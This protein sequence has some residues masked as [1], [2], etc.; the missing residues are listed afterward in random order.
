MGRRQRGFNLLE[1]M[2]SVVVLTAMVVTGVP[3]FTH[4]L[5]KRRLVSA[6]EAA[7]SNLRLLRVE[8]VRHNRNS[9]ANF[10]GDGQLWRYGLDDQALCD[11]AL[12]GDCTVDGNER[13]VESSQ[14]PG[15][16]MSTSFTGNRTGFEP[17]RGT[18]LNAGSVQFRNDAGQLHVEVSLLGS[19]RLCTPPGSEA[20]WGYPDC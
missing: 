19:I 14:Y 3:S 16:T 4:M 12:A 5:N 8:T 10:S 2:T 6:A 11:P 18:A 20:L 17:R 9:F 15:V 1:L 7:V 13:R